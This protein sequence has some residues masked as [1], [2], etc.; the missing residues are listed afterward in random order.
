MRTGRSRC[1][2]ANGTSK[3]EGSWGGEYETLAD[4]S[5][6][7]ITDEWSTGSKVVVNHPVTRPDGTIMPRVSRLRSCTH[8]PARHLVWLVETPPFRAGR[9]QASLLSQFVVIHIDA[10]PFELISIPTLTV[11]RRVIQQ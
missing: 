1:I 3:A 10:A 7:A 8:I 5:G 6:F 11:G 9:K 2:C 4:G